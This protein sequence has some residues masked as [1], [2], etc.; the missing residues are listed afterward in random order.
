M[1]DGGNAMNR[2]HIKKKSLVICAAFILNAFVFVPSIT[3]NIDIVNISTPL[4]KEVLIKNTLTH[5][6][7]LHT[8]QRSM[9][10]NWIEMQKLLTPDGEAGDRFG[11]E[12]SMNEDY[13]LIGAPYDNDNGNWSGSAYV[14]KRTGTNWSQEAKLLPS[15]GAEGHLFGNSVSLDGDTALIGVAW[16]DDNGVDSGSAWVFRRTDGCW[17]PE[18]KLLPSDGKEEVLFGSSVSINGDTALIGAFYDDDNG[19]NSGSAY[20]FKRTGT[21]WSQEAK[22]LPSDGAENDQ[23]GWS[24]SLYNDTALIGAICDDT[25]GSTYVFKRTNGSWS[26]ETKLIPSDATGWEE[27][28]TA[29][30]IDGDT[31][32]IGASLDDDNGAFSGSAYVFKR[33]GTN[34]SQEAKL[35]A[36]DGSE[37]D[38]FGMSVSLNGDYALIGAPL[39]DLY[40]GSAYMFKRANGSW[41]QEAEL[42]SSDGLDG[43]L[44]GVSVSIFGTKALIGT[45]GGFGHGV[46]SGSAYMFN[47][48]G[49][50]WSQEAKILPS[51]GAADDYFGVSVS[52]D[53]DTALIGADYDDMKGSAS[54]FARTSNGWRPQKKL[55][56]SDGAI[57][58]NFGHSVS[59]DGDT[60]LIGAHGDDS[61]TGSAYVFTRSG[62]NWAQQAKLFASDGAQHGTILVFLFLLMVTPPSLEHQVIMPTE[63]MQ[64]PRMFL[65][66]LVPPGYNK[67]NSLLPTVQ[68]EI[69]LVVLFHSL[70]I[71]PS[72][73]HKET[74]DS[75]EQRTYSPAQAS[76]GRSKQRFLLQTDQQ[77]TILVML[78]LLMGTLFS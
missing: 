52:P 47:H 51:D 44:F 69:I 19:H 23:F 72:S 73:G 21:N 78:F 45:P 5:P 41:S 17:S 75:Q 9:P 24:V 15:D 1:V 66:A 27:F 34:W 13:I 40:C 58:D 22:L 67:R 6:T 8:L 36:S 46:Y 65:F 14:F 62:T 18:A 50:N 35:L 31:A 38:E 28:G 59:L 43:Y 76:P 57:G 26:E 11:D 4:P 3:A 25:G 49:T 54:V 61:D 39:N 70:E 77:K 32:L 74:V 29:I 56:A 48:T 37:Y 42:L 71:P 2:N 68:K 7:N 53:N 10:G 20:V 16:D 12:V 64:V 55:F 33:T 63:L 30:S 60:A